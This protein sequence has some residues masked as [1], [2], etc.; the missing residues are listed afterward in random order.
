M[1]PFLMLLMVVWP[2]LWQPCC[3]Q[4]LHRLSATQTCR[5]CQAPASL[6]M[7]H[8]HHALTLLLLL[9][10]L[11]TR[12]CCRLHNPLQRQERL[13]TGWF[14]VI[15]SF[16]GVLVED[17]QHAHA[18]AWLQVAEEMNLPRPL[19]QTLNRI[20]GARDEVVSVSVSGG[21]GQFIRS[22]GYIAA[23][24]RHGWVKDTPTPAAAR[25]PTPMS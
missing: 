8:T 3:C 1:Q 10:L 24:E 9:P 2:L 17:T 16:D 11:S 13:S 5:Y 18:R 7:A 12:P 23:D 19:G 22:L 4:C 14:G 25:P 6:L 21:S 20:K 15:C